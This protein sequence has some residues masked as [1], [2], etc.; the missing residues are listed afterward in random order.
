MGVGLIGEVGSVRPM[1]W[2]QINSFDAKPSAFKSTSGATSSLFFCHNFIRYK[3]T[4]Y[5]ELHP[6][7]KTDAN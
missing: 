3:G 6:T 2:E 5:Y 4:S 7:R 1:L